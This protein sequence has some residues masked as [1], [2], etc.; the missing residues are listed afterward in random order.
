MPKEPKPTDV[1]MQFAA[2]SGVWP[3]VT[4]VLSTADLKTGLSIR[5]GIMWLIHMVELITAAPNLN[6]IHVQ[7]SLSVRDALTVFPKLDDPGVLAHME[8]EAHFNTSGR[9]IWGFPMVSH[10]LPPIPL[11]APNLS[12]YWQSSADDAGLDGEDVIARVGY[13]TSPLD[14][15]AYAEIAETWAYV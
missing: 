10:F 7:V 4:T 6:G 11:A 15:K 12:L 2:F 9:M 14:A 13:T 8:M 1:F 5:G 3:G